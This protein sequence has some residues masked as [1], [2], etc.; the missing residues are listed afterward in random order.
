M[1]ALRTVA[2][3][4]MGGV[5][6][7]GPAIALATYLQYRF[8]RDVVLLETLLVAAC[9]AGTIALGNRLR[10]LTRAPHVRP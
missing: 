5:I 9:I 10:P 2:W 8:D 3:A 4:L 6:S 7:L 1:V